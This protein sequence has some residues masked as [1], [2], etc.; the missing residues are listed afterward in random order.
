[1]KVNNAIFMSCPPKKS[2]SLFSLFDYSSFKG[3]MLLHGLTMLYVSSADRTHKTF[4]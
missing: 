2:S 4:E 1:M 3:K